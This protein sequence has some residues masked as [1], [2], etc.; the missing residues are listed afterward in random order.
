MIRTFDDYL[1][2]QLE[3]TSSWTLLQRELYKASKYTGVLQAAKDIYREEGLPVCALVKYYDHYFNINF[4]F[5]V[6]RD[7]KHDDF[8]FLEYLA[9][10]SN[11]I[12]WNID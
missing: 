11:E 12:Y 8:C 5:M 9:N 4:N 7:S 6:V 2:V 10:L 1:Q 3:P